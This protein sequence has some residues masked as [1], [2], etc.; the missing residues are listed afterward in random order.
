[1][2]EVAYGVRLDSSVHWVFVSFGFVNFNPFGEYAV[3]GECF[4]S[5]L[6]RLLVNA[7]WPFAA[8]LILLLPLVLYTFITTKPSAESASQRVRTMLYQ[9]FQLVLLI[10]YFV[11]PSVS[12]RIFDARKV[13]ICGPGFIIRYRRDVGE[14]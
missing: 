13:R 3:P 9:A 12:R 8:M 6:Q 11:L 10:V 1:M 14:K 2:L 7:L 4:G 5:M